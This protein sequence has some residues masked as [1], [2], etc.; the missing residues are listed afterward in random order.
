MHHLLPL[1]LVIFVAAPAR[2]QGLNAQT[3]APVQSFAA[4]PPLLVVDQQIIVWG[5]DGRKTTGKVVAIT[6]DTVEIS[7]PRL[8]R[9]SQREV[10]AESS[11][12]RI[13]HRDSKANGGFIGLAVGLAISVAVYKTSTCQDLCEVP[14]V[15]L[16]PTVGM[17]IGAEIDA[18]INRPLY[19]SPK[20]TSA[21]TVRPQLGRGTV[22]LASFR[23]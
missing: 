11:V 16:A 10:F 2:A 7:R 22:A 5:E 23:F 21:V 1:L 19:I 14:I 15:T 13:A 3:S 6:G 18:A 8:F 4:L 20:S 12:R 9:R 17:L